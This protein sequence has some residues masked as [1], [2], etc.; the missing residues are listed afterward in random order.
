MWILVIYDIRDTKRLNKI[1]KIMEGYGERL[2][3]SVFGCPLETVDFLRMQKEIKEI[4]K[5]DVDSVKYFPLCVSCQSKG[6]LTGKGKDKI[7]FPRVK[8]I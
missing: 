1:A 7:L 2:Q 4:I 8:I 6:F 5:E 3:K